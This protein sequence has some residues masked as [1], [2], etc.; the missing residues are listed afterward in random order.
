MAFE[1]GL[2]HEQLRLIV[3]SDA[4]DSLEHTKGVYRN[5]K[6][7]AQIVLSYQT[8]D[9][10]KP[11][12]KRQVRL[13]H[14]LQDKYDENIS[15]KRRREAI[16]GW[17]KQVL[18]DA[19]SLVAAEVDPSQSVRSLCEQYVSERESMGRTAGIGK[20]KGFAPTTA[21]KFRCD[22]KRLEGTVM[23]DSAL[24]SVT[25]RMAQ[26]TCNKLCERYSGESVRAVY[27]A[28]RQVFRWAL[29]KHADSPVEDVVLP[30]PDWH[31]DGNRQGVS[32]GLN[33]LTKKG[34]REFITTCL[35]CIGGRAEVTALGGLLGVT[36][37]LRV[38][39][40]C[41]LRWGDVHLDAPVP[42]IHVQRAAKTYVVGGKTV[43]EVG[44]CKTKNAVRKVALMPVAIEA[45]RK[46][47]ASRLELLMACT[48][49]D[50]ERIGIDDC[51]VL[52]DTCGNFRHVTSQ[53][54]SF[55]DFCERR[56]IVGS[57]GRTITA[58]RLRD[59]YAS[60][61]RDAG[62]S[63]VRISKLMGHSSVAVTRARYFDADQDAL[64]DAVLSN[65][66]LFTP[67]TDGE[68]VL[69]LNGTN[70]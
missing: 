58:H 43:H 63:D 38:S 62:E 25:A 50:G 45:L 55:L 29:G 12:G 49:E 11:S 34:M 2:K 30:S 17:K 61:L 44:A 10:S 19:R 27:A 9:P 36:C 64:D 60:R 47:R 28:L 56:G 52:G 16:G 53:V 14:T 32:D 70:G 57:N 33:I 54:Q 18:K 67:F 5:N 69:Q 8:A 20:G 37:G 7:K 15:D 46:V 23:Y 31:P 26:D 6:G 48:P 21:Y 35:E 24:T 41:G 42:Y 66:A 59:T 3:T 4:F 68:D 65:A 51:Y 1:S 39:E 13:T 22:V 40:A